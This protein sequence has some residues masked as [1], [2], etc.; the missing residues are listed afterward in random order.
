MEGLVVV[1]EGDDAQAHRAQQEHP[2]P[3]HF[4]PEIEKEGAG[5]DGEKRRNMSPT[6]DVKKTPT[7]AF[8]KRN[9]P[10]NSWKV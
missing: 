4:H 1:E 2:V 3:S 9:S 8:S 5:G 7:V 10:N 6:N